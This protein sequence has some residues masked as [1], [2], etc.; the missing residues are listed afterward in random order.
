MRVSCPAIHLLSI[1]VMREDTGDAGVSTTAG[2]STAMGL[3]LPSGI[4][5]GMARGWMDILQ[6]VPSRFQTARLVQP[7]ARVAGF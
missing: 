1:A 2:V 5:T 7:T 3:S 4:V 6:D